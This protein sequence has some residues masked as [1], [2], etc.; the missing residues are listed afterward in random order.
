MI[1]NA[2]YILEGAR[3]QGK[4]EL[5]RKLNEKR[6]VVHST[7]IDVGWNKTYCGI[8]ATEKTVFAE[9]HIYVSCKRCLIKNSK[10][11]TTTS[12]DFLL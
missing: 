10:S 4:T 8:I 3:R 7:S 12:R 6:I 9:R 1:A 11:V 2:L 5:I